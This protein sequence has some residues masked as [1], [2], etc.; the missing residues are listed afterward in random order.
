M[1]NYG[2]I[3]LKT[4]RRIFYMSK[5]NCDIQNAAVLGFAVEAVGDDNILFEYTG[6]DRDIIVPDG[7]TIIGDSAFTDCEGI[8]SVKL[9]ESLTIIGEAAFKQCTHLKSITM[10]D[11]LTIIG[12]S[13]FTDCINLTEIALPASIRTI[14]KFAFIKCK[15]LELCKV[16]KGSYAETH[17]HDHYPSIQIEYI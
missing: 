10:P 8:A 12:E 1:D 9:P 4:E 13:A 6:E 11:S 17:L 2:I 16:T 15:R 14:G 5:T 3:N 7:I